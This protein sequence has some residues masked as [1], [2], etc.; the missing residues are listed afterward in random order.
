MNED[1]PTAY[2]VP[3]SSIPLMQRGPLAPAGL[4]CGLAVSSPTTVMKATTARR[5]QWA[6]DGGV[7]SS[8]LLARHAFIAFIAAREPG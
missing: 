1:E 5:T 3:I 8:D 7:R 4:T 6:K 2:L